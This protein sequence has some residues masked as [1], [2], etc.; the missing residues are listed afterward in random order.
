MKK[1]IFGLSFIAVLAVFSG[2]II[3]F[4]FDPFQ[5]AGYVKVLF[6]ASL[7]ALIWSAGTILFLYLRRDKNAGSESSFIKSLLLSVIIL[8]IFLGLRL[9]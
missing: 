1:E 2:G 9:K 8:G 6:Y 5:S 3:I 4:N 7:F